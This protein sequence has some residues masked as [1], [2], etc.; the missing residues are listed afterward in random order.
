[1]NASDWAF[2]A[3]GCTGSFVAV[4]HGVVTQ[5]RMIEPIL[6]QISF[7]ESTR[8]L[9]PLL[10]HFSTLCWFFGG[11]ALIAIPFVLETQAA[12]TTAAFVGTFYSIG[13]V[14]NLWGTKGRHPG[15][16]L[17]S[18]AAALIVYGSMAMIK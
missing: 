1:M 14:G 2:V 16:I 12:L 7:P 3:A 8:R 9:I 13:A 15:W 6:S 11:I 4:F 5:K 18:L 10:L 17:L